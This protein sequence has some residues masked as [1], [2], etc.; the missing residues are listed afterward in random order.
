[1]T[2]SANASVLRLESGQLVLWRAGEA[3]PQSAHAITP[4]PDNTVFAAPASDVR[5]VETEVAGD[6]AK[7]L[8]K[9]L[10][11]I[12]EEEVIDD[13][14]N[15]HFAYRSLEGTGLQVAL[16]ART[17]VEHWQQQLPDDFDG[18]WIPESLLLPVGSGEACLVVEEDSVLIRWSA[19]EGARL[20]PS[21]V[22]ALLD[23]LDTP[24]STLIIYGH[25]QADDKALAPAAMQDR[26]QWRNGGFGH[27]LLLSNVDEA[28]LDLRQGDYAP[29]LPLHRWWGHW[30]RVAVVAGIALTL[31]LGADLLTYQRLKSENLALRSAIQD[32]YRQANPKGAV[33]DVEKQLDRQ[34]AEY[35]AGVAG[36]AFTPLL[37]TI[38]QALALEGDV[39]VSTLNFNS[40]NGEIRLDLLADNYTSVESLRQRLE[41][42]GMVA[43]L[44][45]SSSREDRVRA[46]LRIEARRT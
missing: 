33:V 29:R 20:A 23:S 3:A 9:S 24:P 35:N 5:V 37:A 1:M 7:H 44:E 39:S 21:L 14:D 38:T 18:Q 40:G 25:N 16:A 10:P 32:S 34:L 6:E 8:R 15:L 28:Q 17:S 27:A 2:V 31:Q 13:I 41:Q 46:R 4:W 43:T 26:I 12:M 42:S 22:S 30:R 45:T 19:T 11:F 36:V